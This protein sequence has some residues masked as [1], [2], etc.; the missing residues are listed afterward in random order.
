MWTISTISREQTTSLQ[1][2]SNSHMKSTLIFVG[3]LMLSAITLAQ[4][5]NM[6]NGGS[7]STCSG[8]F[9]DPGGTANYT[10]GNSTWNYT[11]CNPSAPSP[12]YID[13][14]SFSLRNP[15]FCSSD[16]LRIYNGPSTASPL[17]GTYTANNSPGLVVGSSGCL[18]F[19]FQRYGTGFL[20]SSGGAPGWTAT[21]SCTAPPPNGDNCFV[22]TPFCSSTAYNFPNNTGTSS[23]SGPNYGCL[24]AQP[25]PVWY[26]MQIGTSGPMQLALSQT[27][28][29]GG[30]GLPIDVDFALYGPVANLL[31]G[32]NAVMSGSLNPIQCSYSSSATETL[33]L[34]VIGGVGSGQSTPASAVA[35]QTYIVLLTN[36]SG[37][38]GY[39][40]FSQSGGS[41]TADCAIVLPVELAAFEGKNEGSVNKLEWITATEHNSSHFVLER[42]ADGFFWNQVA[43]VASKGNTN[44][45]SKYTSYDDSFEAQVNYYRLKQVD[46]NGESKLSEVVVIDN[47]LSEKVLMKIV[48]SLGQEVNA[49]NEGLVFFLYE[50]GTVVKKMN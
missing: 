18:T 29:A 47:R 7:A 30:T 9:Y 10:S 43:Y 38:S 2:L 13:F 22:S 3:T 6:S 15:L 46:I 39:I 50:D 19:Q 32:C 31:A 35:G 40:S 44:E 27:T 37:S 26:Y 41:G 14:T 24:A 17:I 16:V 12:I 49:N 28:G 34:G 1:F 11:I 25:N 45:M 42:S 4:T 5:Y 20:C 36:Y 48:N 21:I 8:T 23:P 33:G